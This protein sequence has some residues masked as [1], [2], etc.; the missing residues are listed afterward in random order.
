MADCRICSLSES[1]PGVTL[2]ER[3]ICNLCKLEVGD[4]LLQNVTFASR[5][6]AEFKASPPNPHG[7]HDCLLMFS[8]GKD[9]TYLLDKFVNEY[10][11]RVLAYTFEIPFESDQAASNVQLV[12]SRIPATYV[13]DQD[14]ASIKEV[15]RAAFDR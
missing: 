5:V 8:G 11:K 6:Y 7:L 2:D 3:Q 15:V 14:D 10:H 12:Q 13:V 1:H 9:S 4:E